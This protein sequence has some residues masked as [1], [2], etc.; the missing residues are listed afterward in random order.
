MAIPSEIPVRSD[1]VLHHQRPAWS[2]LDEL[3]LWVI[4]LASAA[5]MLLIG[6][7]A[8]AIPT[9]CV[10]ALVSITARATPMP[11][12]MLRGLAA[13]AL[14]ATLVTAKHPSS[15]LDA[16]TVGALLLIAFVAVPMGRLSRSVSGRAVADHL[17]ARR[18]TVGL[19]EQ[20]RLATRRMH[21][22]FAS[23]DEVYFETD[24]KVRLRYV[25]ESCERAT[26]VSPHRL[27]GLD[28]LDIAERFLGRYGRLARC[29]AWMGRHKII[30]GHRIAFC[31]SHGARRYFT[32]DAVPRY[33]RFGRFTGYRGVIN[34]SRRRC[35]R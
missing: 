26:G 24:D 15:R 11:L 4:A 18:R 13:L 3:S 34:V 9:L 17:A 20:A 32:V 7:A 25:S 22:F 6:V 21:D 16:L 12:T 8:A 29:G 28:A 27:L 19:E 33:G 14:I 31:D 23:S 5:L 1:T 2:R 10:A 35:P 30:H